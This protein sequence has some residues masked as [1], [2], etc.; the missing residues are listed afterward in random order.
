MRCKACSAAV[1]YTSARLLGD[2]ESINLSDVQE[3]LCDNCLN[4]AQETFNELEEMKG[5]ELEAL[6][7]HTSVSRDRE[8]EEVLLNTLT[9]P[10][11]S[12]YTI[13]T[14]SYFGG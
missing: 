6:T 14:D 11:K 10:N 3:D 1:S 9:E 8:E 7:R 12:W 4:V 2:D 5:E 13:D